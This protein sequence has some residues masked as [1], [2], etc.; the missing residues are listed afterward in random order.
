M[1]LHPAGRPG[2][3]IGRTEGCL[4]WSSSSERCPHLSQKQGRPSLTAKIN[5]L[6]S[7]NFL[8]SYCSILATQLSV[9]LHR[10]STQKIKYEEKK[11]INI[12]IERSELI[13]YR[14]LKL[15]TTLVSA[16]TTAVHMINNDI[17]VHWK[18]SS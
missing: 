13:W 8:T 9:C 12:V 4:W 1:Y 6:T 17:H 10:N 18:H 16:S 5:T 14:I 7:N 15:N 2:P 3:G 11:I